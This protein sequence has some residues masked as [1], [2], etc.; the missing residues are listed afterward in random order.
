M[1][2][3]IKNDRILTE[4]DEA[5]LPKPQV[6]IIVDGNS[7]YKPGMKTVFAENLTRIRGISATC[8]TDSEALCTCDTVIQGNSYPTIGVICTC[9]A[10]VDCSCDSHCTCQ[11]VGSCPYNTVGGNTSGNT[12]GNTG[13]T[14]GT[15]GGSVCTCQSVSCNGPCACVPVH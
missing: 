12:G 13:G 15:T 8:P 3:E 11:N 9:E 7:I 6:K 4:E 1:S 10:H 14:G 5:V 2:E